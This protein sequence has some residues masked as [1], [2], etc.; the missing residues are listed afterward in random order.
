MVH[1]LSVSFSSQ[2]AAWK[3]S[4]LTGCRYL[5]GGQRAGLRSSC[6][7]V[8]E[9]LLAGDPPEDH[10]GAGQAAVPVVRLADRRDVQQD[11]STV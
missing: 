6:D 8:E 10:L 1:T 7:R 11:G 2:Q 3:S 9:L 4:S 5:Q